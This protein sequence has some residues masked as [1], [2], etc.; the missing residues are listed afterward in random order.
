MFRFT[1]E[2]YFDIS[3]YILCNTHLNSL[4]YGLCWACALNI[5]QHNIS[6]IY[7]CIYIYISLSVCVCGNS[8]TPKLASL[9]SSVKWGRSPCPD[10]YLVWRC[11]KTEDVLLSALYTVND[12]WNPPQ[13]VSAPFFSSASGSP[14]LN[15]RGFTTSPA[16]TWFQATG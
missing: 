13:L 2:S 16:L 9:G 8:S 15:P 11:L 7:T 4:S 10:A 12:E 1:I 3:R 14:L 6:C 5:T